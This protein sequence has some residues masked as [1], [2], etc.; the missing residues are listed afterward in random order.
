MN[1]CGSF[2]KLFN[3]S[4]FHL[5]FKYMEIIYLYIYIKVSSSRKMINMFPYSSCYEQNNP[6]KYTQN[7][8]NK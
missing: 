3:I 2:S 5:T 4:E 1:K 7:D 6:E 8:K